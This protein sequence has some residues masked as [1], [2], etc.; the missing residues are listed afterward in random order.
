MLSLAQ[1]TVSVGVQELLQAVDLLKQFFALV[2]VFDAHA[3]TSEILQ[4]GAVVDVGTGEDSLLA[5]LERL[6]LYQLFLYP[7][8]FPPAVSAVPSYVFSALSVLIVS[9]AGVMLSLPS[10]FVTLL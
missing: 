2:R 1:R 4:Q 5:R 3:L 9:F 8:T 10:V 7:V 6:V